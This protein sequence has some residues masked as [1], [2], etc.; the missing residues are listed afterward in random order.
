MGDFQTL[1]QKIEITKTLGVNLAAISTSF[2]D[3]EQALR[4]LILIGSLV[5]TVLQIRKL[6]TDK[7]KNEK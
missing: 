2:A 5:Y 3:I 4:L 1:N 7:T 6:L